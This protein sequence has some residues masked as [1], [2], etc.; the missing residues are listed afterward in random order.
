MSGFPNILN[1]EG[2]LAVVIGGGEVAF[3][4]AG[5]FLDGGARV[6][7][8]SPEVCAGLREL[9]GKGAVE[10]V[11]RAYQEG[12]LKDAFVCAAC[13]DDAVVN[14][15]VRDHAR[16]LGVL[17]NISDDPFGS[18]FQVPSYFRQGPLL[19]ALSTSGASPA[20]A[21]T[22]RR[23]LQSYLGEHMGEAI[24]RINTFREKVVKKEIENPADRTR[25]WEEALTADLMELARI[26]EHD[27]IRELL[28]ESLQ[29]FKRDKNR[30][31]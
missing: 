3:R 9:A 12:D 30:R 14:R 20:V 24:E 28:H 7:V 27:R 21:R 5:N 8:I 31:Y 29:K 4:K 26:G 1:I 15:N 2:V 17:A 11:E 25:F 19:M 18:D 10:L 22:L 13:T 16:E 23:M 6:K